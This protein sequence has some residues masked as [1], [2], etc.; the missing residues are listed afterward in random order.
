[1]DEH[2]DYVQRQ[3]IDILL[4]LKQEL[5]MTKKFKNIATITAAVLSLAIFSLPAFADDVMLGTGGY[6]R[7]MNNMKLMAMLDSNNDHM[8][9]NDEYSVFYEDAFS[10]LDKN[11]DGSLDE[12]EWIGKRNDSTA[13]FGTG[14][15]NREIRKMAMMKAID[16][17]GD[18]KVSKEEFLA[19][20]QSVFNKMD[21]SSDQQL[22]A[23]EWTGKILGG[24]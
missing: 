18:H 5:I 24:K 1:M 15:Y 11:G 19:F 10:K 6:N 9:T 21:K 14:G 20:H 12:K 23:Q 7:E 4:N 16:S 17:D 2:N 22:S 8:V 13:M 3:L